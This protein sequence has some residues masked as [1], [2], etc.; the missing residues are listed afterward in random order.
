MEWRTGRKVGRWGR[1]STRDEGGGAG[2]GTRTRAARDG[3]ERTM[4]DRNERLF[5][6]EVLVHDLVA[7]VKLVFGHPGGQQVLFVAPAVQALL[8][9]PPGRRPRLVDVG[10]EPAAPG[11]VG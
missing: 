8:Q 1:A 3:H 9:V 10:V 5:K 4:C 7:V 11:A 6:A 2:P